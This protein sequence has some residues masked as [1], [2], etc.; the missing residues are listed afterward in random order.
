MNYGGLG[1]DFSTYKKSKI[2]VLPIPYDETTTW[3]KG[4]SKGPQAIIEA[5][6]NMELYDLE[7]NTNIA[8][9]GIHTVA[10]MKPDKKPEKMIE[11]I[12]NTT[13]KLLKDNKFVVGLGGEHTISTGLVKAHKEAYPDLSVIFL[14]AHFDLREEY[15]SGKYDHACTASRI[16]EMCPL[17]EIGVRSISED[18]E[19]RVDWNKTFLARD[20][21]GKKD[22]VDRAF[23]NLGKNVYVTIDLDVI[24]PSE[25]P[26]VGTPEPGGLSWYDLTY[27]LGRVAE[28]QNVVG[29]DVVELCPN[30]NNKAP[31]FLASKL[32]YSFL[33]QI[34]KTKPS[35]KE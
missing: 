34:F 24:D 23:R 3:I 27:F 30:P 12:K 32:V 5:S 20:V 8:E 22:W 18:E 35:L 16:K 17:I 15:N 6:A 11:S 9:K 31:D 14:D 25:M 19:E 2:A 21:I 28:E 7:T 1:K 26:S 10:P 4:A 29:F 13:S 33:S